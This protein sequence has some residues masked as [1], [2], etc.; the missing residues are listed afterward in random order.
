[1]F[2]PAGVK[3]GKPGRFVR[4]ETVESPGWV[5]WSG[6]KVFGSGQADMA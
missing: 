6:I 2:P 1:M 4:V 3:I 5:A